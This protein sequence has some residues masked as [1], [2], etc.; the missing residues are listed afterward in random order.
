MPYITQKTSEAQFNTALQNFKTVAAANAVVLGLGED[1]LGEINDAAVHFNLD[2]NAWMAAKASAEAAKVTKDEQ[3]VTSR[4]VVSKWAKIWRANPDI[5]DSLLEQLTLA[6]HEPTVVKTPPTPVTLPTAVADGNGNITLRWNRNGNIQS[7]QFVIETID[8]AS[9]EWIVFGSTT[10]A[11]FEME[12]TPGAY[13][14]MRITA[15]RSGLS[16]TPSTPVYL[17]ADD[18]PEGLS[19]AA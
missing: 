3:L 8:T 12:W 16:S 18:A 1:E 19:V 2:L 11:K 15:Q 6:P 10:K 17:W 14:G 9:G 13:L 4:A 7:T 5:P